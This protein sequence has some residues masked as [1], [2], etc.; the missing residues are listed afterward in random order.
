MPAAPPDRTPTPSATCIHVAIVHMPY[1]HPYRL[2][3]RACRKIQHRVA[4]NMTA[5][6]AAAGVKLARRFYGDPRDCSAWGATVCGTFASNGEA[7]KLA[8]YLYGTMSSWLDLLLDPN[9]PPERAGFEAAVRVEGPEGGLQLETSRSCEPA[10]APDVPPSPPQQ[11]EAPPPVGEP[12]YVPYMCTACVEVELDPRGQDE[13]EPVF[14][15]RSPLEKGDY[16]L[17]AASDISRNL[18]DAGYPTS[19]SP[20]GAVWLQQPQMETCSGKTPAGAYQLRVCGSLEYVPYQLEEYA[21]DRDRGPRSWLDP[22]LLYRRS[23]GDT[24]D[25]PGCLPRL[26][27]ATGDHHYLLTARMVSNDTLGLPCLGVGELQFD[28]TAM[29]NFDYDP[30]SPVKPGDLDPPPPPIPLA[31]PMPPFLPP[32]PP[33]RP[34]PPPPNP[35]PP[36]PPNC[37]FCVWLLAGRLGQRFSSAQCA[38]FADAV[39]R[40]V[41]AAAGGRYG[42]VYRDGDDP[43][44]NL[45]RPTVC[46]T[47]AVREGGNRVWD[48]VRARLSGLALAAVTGPAAGGGSGGSCPTLGGQVLVQAQEGRPSLV[49]APDAFSCFP[50]INLTLSCNVTPGDAFPFR[51]ACIADPASTPFTV[52]RVVRDATDRY[53]FHLGGNAN[54]SSW[55]NPKGTCATAA[56]LASLMLQANTALNASLISITTESPSG[57]L[58][59]R[60]GAAALAAAWEQTKATSPRYL[61]VIAL[62]WTAA[63]LA[64]PERQG[65]VCLQLAPNT[66]LAEF[67]RVRPA[68]VGG[69]GGMGVGACFLSLVPQGASECCPTFAYNSTGL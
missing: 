1:D 30:P 32:S 63:S 39:Q 55:P 46:F 12:P 22:F 51:A 58:Q 14:G 9:C 50:R 26:R 45:L 67:C 13:G 7:A 54:T 25:T 3:V 33:P 40:N 36:P 41:S 66:S 10:A 19:A 47:S 68:I 18:V 56:K 43:C 20:Y 61:D 11:P 48:Q 59:R 52:A 49:P 21:S 42:L 60:A 8:N 4:T 37:D 6:A 53:C 15:A 27:N 38:A 31:P 44:S 17:S 34:R 35:P 28:C 64:P 29:F 23:G 69:A 65:K 57:T 5:A 16:C 62:D 24:P 2:T